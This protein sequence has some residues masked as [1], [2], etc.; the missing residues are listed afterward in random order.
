VDPLSEKLIEAVKNPYRGPQPDPQIAYLIAGKGEEAVIVG[1]I[2]QQ[3][4]NIL[5]QFGIRVFG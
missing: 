4:Y 1:N 3:S 5:M 2:D